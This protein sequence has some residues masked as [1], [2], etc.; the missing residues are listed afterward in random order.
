MLSLPI[1]TAS[2]SLFRY[3]QMTWCWKASA[4]GVLVNS[5]HCPSKAALLSL[6]RYQRTAW[7]WKAS[8]TGVL[9]NSYYCP[10]KAA[11]LSL[12]RYQR[13]AWYWRAGTTQWQWP[14]MAASPP[15]SQ[16]KPH[17]PHHLHLEKFQVSAHCLQS[18]VIRRSSCNTSSLTE[19]L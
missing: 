4:I 2:L 1:N 15:P 8:A 11:L 5:Y 3:S 12:S 14:S 6:S 10:W 19:H 18:F 16:L 13:M 9:A 17:H 7:C